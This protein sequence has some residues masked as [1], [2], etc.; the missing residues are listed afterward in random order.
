MIQKRQI[1]DQ[2][3]M[4]MNAQGR[5]DVEFL[6]KAAKG[7]KV[8]LEKLMGVLDEYMTDS[9]ADYKELL[10]SDLEGQ[11]RSLQEETE[12]KISEV[13]AYEELRR[14]IASWEITG[15]VNGKAE[16][17]YRALKEKKKICTNG[18]L[19]LLLG[20]EAETDYVEEKT[21]YAD[22][23]SHALSRQNPEEEKE[24]KRLQEERASLSEEIGR[25]EKEK[26]EAETAFRELVRQ[27]AEIRARMEEERPAV[28]YLTKKIRREGFFGFLFDFL[29]KA[30]T[31]TVVD[32]SELLKWQER[33]D[34]VQKEYDVKAGEE[35]DRIETLKNNWREK[36]EAYDRLDTARRQLEKRLRDMLKAELLEELEVFLRGEGGLFDQASASIEKDLN[37]NAGR[38][39]DQVWAEYQKRG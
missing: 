6:A 30:K 33:V 39:R 1:Y 7:R 13:S 23:R 20:A 25:I 19:R 17:V 9:F 16:E 15:F 36:E 2:E 10:L 35:N 34:E 8:H 4:D 32:D 24:L 14:Q 18:I 5:V 26:E 22:F 11:I 21:E 29:G 37:L 3:E 28:K 12:E 31:E 38:I 27:N